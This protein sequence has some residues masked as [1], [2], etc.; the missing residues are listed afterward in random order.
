MISNVYWYYSLFII[1]IMLCSSQCPGCLLYSSPS[2]SSYEYLFPPSPFLHSS[3]FLHPKCHSCCKWFIVILFSSLT[4]SVLIHITTPSFASALV[5]VLL[6]L[7]IVLTSVLHFH[8]LSISDCVQIL[9]SS[10]TLKERNAVWPMRMD[11]WHGCRPIAR[12][13]TSVEDWRRA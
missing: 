6:W 7:I 2:L 12:T 10:S 4:P 13:T 5:V 8:F 1:N 11:E 3:C 9:G